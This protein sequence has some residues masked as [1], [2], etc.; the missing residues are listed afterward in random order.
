[1][2]K[3]DRRDH[4]G[5]WHHVMNRAVGRRPFFESDHE[6]RMFL[7]L[8]ARAVR[9]GWL[10]VHAFA[11]LRT[12]FHLL[13]RTRARGI[14]DSLAWIQSRYVQA[15]NQ[16][17]DRDGP[18]VRNGFFSNSVG[19]R[20][21]RRVLVGYIDWNPVQARLCDRPVQYPH[22]SARRFV[23][24]PPKWLSSDWIRSLLPD[25]DLD[26]GPYSRLFRPTGRQSDSIEYSLWD[27]TPI[28]AGVRARA[29]VADGAERWLRRR[30]RLADG[31]ATRGSRLI[32]PELLLEA[33]REVDEAALPLAV[34]V[35]EVVSRCVLVGML[36]SLTGQTFRGVGLCLG[37][38]AE[39][40]HALWKRHCVRIEVDAAYSAWCAAF[41][42][43]VLV[44]EAEGVHNPAGSS[45]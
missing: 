12:H 3:I 9:R 44:D 30:A 35:D 28:A 33:W 42:E 32:P 27:R 6:I 20:V 10:E 36:R 34:H 41:A 13:V 26:E 7:S 4:P 31:D 2:P 11:I 8:V 39:R 23:A 16:L 43:R 15:F 14:S 1:M 29:I 19:D 22:G 21:Y 25:G 40:A 5:A 45:C 37:I 17:H 18:L 24:G 38:S